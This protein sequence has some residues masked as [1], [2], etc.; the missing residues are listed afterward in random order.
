[1][2]E[3]DM[4]VGELFAGLEKLGVMDDTIIVYS[5]DNGPEHSAKLFPSLPTKTTAMMAGVAFVGSLLNA[6]AE[7]RQLHGFG[8]AGALGE[9]GLPQ[10][11]VPLALKT[12]NLDVEAGQLLFVATVLLLVAACKRLPLRLPKWI[13]AKRPYAIGSLAMFWVIERTW[14]YTFGVFLP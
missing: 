13:E 8:F 14:D 4:Q 12:F 2:I 9:I 11:L 6:P 5:T 10:K 7:G 3:H 1:M